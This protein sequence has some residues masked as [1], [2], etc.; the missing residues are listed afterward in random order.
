MTEQTR[1][2][3]L[4][5]ALTRIKTLSIQIEELQN[6]REDSLL[7]TIQE[8]RKDDVTVKQFLE[9]SK[10]NWD[11][12]NDLIS[13]RNAMRDAVRRANDKVTVTLGGETL[14]ITQVLNRK[15]GLKEHFNFLARLIRHN[16]AVNENVLRSEEQVEK[17][18]RSQLA[19][20]VK[21]DT[22]PD[23]GAQE[24][25]L[26]TFRESVRK[27]K[28]LVRLSGISEK[29]LKSQFEKVKMMIEEMD[30]VLSE[31][32]ATNTVTLD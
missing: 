4:T 11:Q 27:E 2:Y 28:K 19:S 24:A 1:T 7:G 8:T 20:V 6:I 31:A 13:E 12:Y 21:P 3:T 5:R 32:N 22:A 26:N 25:L 29:E 18:A 15:D 30:Y 17:E 23:A 9:N 14:T 10:A 16:E